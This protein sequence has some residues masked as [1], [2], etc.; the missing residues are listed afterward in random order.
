MFKSIGSFKAILVAAMSF[1]AISGIAD[2]EE[3]VV[4]NAHTN[5]VD[6][7]PT[8]IINRPG[9]TPTGII[10]ANIGSQMVDI[11]SKAVTLDI[12]TEFGIVKDL[13]GK[14]SYD[15][16]QFNE[17]KAKNTF[18]L[19]AQYKFFG[20]SNM[21]N[22]VAVKLP[23]HVGRDADGTDHIV[24]SITLGLPTTFFNNVMAGGIL[25][26]VFTLT[27]RPNVAV[28]FDFS[29]WY[30]VQVY[31]DLWAQVKSSF[32]KIEMENP[33]NQAKWTAKGFWKELPAKLE[34][35][36]A[37]N[38]YFDITGNAGFKN[39]FEPK[40]TFTFGLNLGVHGGRIFG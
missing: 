8:Q 5:L 25:G 15:G 16:F 10:T 30:G 17:W 14:F 39:V 40:D 23:I 18:N 22:S 34:L 2:N 26:D 1:L 13:E 37:L 4:E 36:Y 20:M 12:G 3:G 38:H 33:N 35:T 11:K 28:A 21:S 31:G 29:A 24:R 7:Y 9:I 19:G 32:G 6:R 27:M